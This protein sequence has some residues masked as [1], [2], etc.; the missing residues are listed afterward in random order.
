LALNLPHITR[1]SIK[2]ERHMSTIFDKKNLLLLLP[3]S[4]TVVWAETFSP[5]LL[6]D[7]RSP[8]IVKN[9][10]PASLLPMITT[11]LQSRP[12]LEK[13]SSYVSVKLPQIDK[14][15][16]ELACLHE[17]TLSLSNTASLKSRLIV[18][19]ECSYPKAWKQN[20]PVQV[21]IHYPVVTTQQSLQRGETI[22]AEKL[23]LK[24][25]DILTLHDGFFDKVED[26]LGHIAKQSIL[27][28]RWLSPRN[29]EA[30]KLVK[31][32]EFVSVFTHKPGFEVKTK[33]KALSD[34]TLGARIKVEN[35]GS[36]QVIEGVIT[37]PQQVE[38]FL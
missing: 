26:A 15:T 32:G 23:I 4:A 14:K 1:I 27:A 10:S 37:A 19:A 17:P 30:P 22:T 21:A 20:I 12:F 35:L 28:G 33:A 6:L 25:L 16:T 8:E 29:I 18:K 24:P 5:E 11:F 3:L 13:Y 36:K 2:D 31:R 9:Y 7:N 38:V 34:G